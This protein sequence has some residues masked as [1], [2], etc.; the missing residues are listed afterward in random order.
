MVFKKPLF[1]QSINPRT[2]FAIILWVMLAWVLSRPLKGIGENIYKILGAATNNTFQNISQTKSTAEELLKSKFLVQEQ[3][4]TI[5]LLKI[6]I[7]YLENQ[8][9]ESDNLRNLLSL[10]KV[11]HYKTIAAS[12][13][14]RSADNWHKQIILDK[15]QDSGIMIGDSILSTKGVIGQVV[16]IT[17]DFST[18]QLISDPSYRLG[19]KIANKDI[20]G[21]LAGKTNS[22]G[23]VYFIPIGSNVK[24][25]DL[26]VTSG[27]TT[28]NLS[29][30]YPA[31]HPIGRVSKV[32][33]EKSKASDLYI[34]VKLT[35]DLNSL[36]NVLVFSPK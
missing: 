13:I 2:A 25:G 32:S 3:S 20:L 22:V 9:K 26:V 14:G 4:K 34:E 17:K 29:L 36:S 35:E 16:D 6:K 24:V 11:L 10:K 12:V 30:T 1:I 8:I 18:V 5:S 31:N 28:G 23:L 19:C 33:K 27:I 7:N 21:I 15:G